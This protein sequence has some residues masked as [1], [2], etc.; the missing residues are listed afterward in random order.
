L[1]RIA[2]GK[3]LGANAP[4]LDLMDSRRMVLAI[5]ELYERL[6]HPRLRLRREHMCG[7]ITRMKGA[8]Q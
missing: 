1:R 2:A 8:K 6:L 7:A 5:E 4:G 3:A